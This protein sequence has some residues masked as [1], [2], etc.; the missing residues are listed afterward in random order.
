MPMQ[1]ISP[2]GSGKC[3]PDRPS[4]RCPHSVLIPSWAPKGQS[5][6]CGLCT[7]TPAAAPTGKRSQRVPAEVENRE[8]EAVEE[9]ACAQ[10]EEDC[11]LEE[12]ED[13]VP[14]ETT[15]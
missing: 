4:D 9:E 3:S 7:H 10:P 6:Y 8:E 15:A 1:Q 13:Y 2:L 5:P 14:E 12:E 11:D